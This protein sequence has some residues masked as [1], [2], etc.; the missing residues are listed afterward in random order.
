[1]AKERMTAASTAN[2]PAASRPAWWRSLGPDGVVAALLSV[3]AFLNRRGGLPHDG[4]WFDDSWVA[5]GALKGSFSQLLTVGSAHPGFT[6][7]LMAWSQVT[8]SSSLGLA[9]PA[10]VA[11]TLGPPSLYLVLRRFGYARSISVLL[12]A[13]L[14]VGDVDIV[15]SGRVKPYVL[16]ILIV[17]GLMAIVPSLAR[18]RWRWP[19]AVGWVAAA[20]LIAS[21]SGFAFVAIAGAGAIFVLHPSSDRPLRVCAVAVQAVCQLIILAVLQERS[22]LQ[23]VEAVLERVFDAHIDFDPNPLAFGSELL[24]HLRRVAVVAFPGGPSWWFSVCAI[25][26]VIGLTAAALSRRRSVALA[27]RY[28]A[29]LLFVAFVG[30]V[31]HRFA[32]GPTGGPPFSRGERYSLW[33]APVMAFGAAVFLQHVR[34]LAGRRPP[35][36]IGFDIVVAV[37]AAVVLVSGLGDA[38]PYPFSG[39][40]SATEFVDS[41]L[42]EHDAV[43]ITLT[44]VYTF[45]VESRSRVTL[46]ATPEKVIGFIPVF[47]DARLH[48]VGP[49]GEVEGR[50]EQIR[51][52]VDNA[53]RV[54]V[55]NAIPF[56]GGKQSKATQAALVSLGFER[57]RT[58][59]FNAAQ[60]D[61]WRRD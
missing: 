16:D 23:E 26:A 46:R 45:A 59:R 27:G 47:A 7:L 25:L 37:V 11:G 10:L 39:S 15:Y 29:L 35:M 48:T 32:F 36:R 2:K 4:L 20:I 5:T 58:V 8:G 60:V 30:G 28:L 50:S 40:R 14:V 56:I 3:T 43:I 57:K 55:H 24:E 38:L 9:Y 49:F 21:F 1:V 31:I 34:G 54:F 6:G 51:A 17:I 41:E 42:T 19:T 52:L 61:I 33:L 53:D 18:V 22:N 12:G 44:S 13:S